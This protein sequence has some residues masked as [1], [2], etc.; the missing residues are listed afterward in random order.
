MATLGRSS[1]DGKG[2]NSGRIAQSEIIHTVAGVFFH[3]DRIKSFQTPKRFFQDLELLTYKQFR[4]SSIDMLSRECSTD[5]STVYTRNVYTTYQSKQKSKVRQFFSTL[6][7]LEN[8]VFRQ[9]LSPN[10]GSGESK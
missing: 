2:L 1:H 4:K 6:K 8:W 10:L 3:N 5:R 7:L 9:S